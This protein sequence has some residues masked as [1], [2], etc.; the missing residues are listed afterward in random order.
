MSYLEMNTEN[1][2]CIIAGNGKY[3]NIHGND[4]VSNLRNVNLW[5]KASGAR[6][7]K[8][9]FKSP[10]IFEQMNHIY[11]IT[12]DIN[13]KYGLNKNTGSANLNNCDM[14]PVADNNINDSGV[15]IEPVHS[16]HVF[17]PLQKYKIKLK[18]SNLV[19]TTKGNSNGSDVRWEEDIHEQY[20]EGGIGRPTQLWDI[21]V[22]KQK[23]LEDMIVYN[24]KWNG[25]SQNINNTGCA[26]CCGAAVSSFYSGKDILPTSLP[27]NSGQDEDGFKWVSYGF[28]SPHAEMTKS[29]TVSFNKICQEIDLGYP[30][31][32]HGQ[33]SKPSHQHWVVIYG[34]EGDRQGFLNEEQDRQRILVYD[35]YNDKGNL[36]KH[37]VKRTLQ[38][39]MDLS[40][41][42]FNIDRLVLTRPK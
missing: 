4:T 31:I 21:V 29:S 27:Y 9:H 42:C 15:V 10:G 1:K 23:K 7:Q 11:Q 16:Y 40:Y 41:N 18:D 34:Y 38:E 28:T 33:G 24:Q 26:L 14:Y 19:L 2:Y 17:L 36:E 6:S 32:V 22:V 39:A 3:L 30:I 12:T 37:G 35:T 13:E 8:W 25:F 20:P 5:D